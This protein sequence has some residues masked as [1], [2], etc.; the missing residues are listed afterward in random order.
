VQGG[1]QGNEFR[2]PPLWVGMKHPY[3]HDGRARSIADAI[4]AHRGQALEVRDAYFAL[5]AAEQF[6]VQRF[7]KR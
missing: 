7:L 6:A 3:L 4:D 5:P 1:A 2:T